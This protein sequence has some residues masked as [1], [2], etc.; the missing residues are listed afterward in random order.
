VLQQL[1]DAERQLLA[2]RAHLATLAGKEDHLAMPN[3]PRNGACE[4]YPNLEQWLHD[5]G[6]SIVHRRPETPLDTTYDR[7]A[8][9]LGTHFD[10]LRPFYTAMKRC[11][12]G[13]PFAIPISLKDATP[14]Q[15]STVVQFGRDLHRHGFLKA[16]RYDQRQRLLY[17]QAQDAG[18]VTNFFTGAW[19]DR[20]VLLRTQASLRRQRV[21]VETLTNLQVVLPDGRDFELDIL[22]GS[23]AGILW[24]ECKTGNNYPEFV[25]RYGQIAKR[26]MCLP[27]TRCA[28]VLLE[29]LTEDE[30]QSNTVL[31]GMSVLNLPDL[32]P[33][34]AR[35][36]HA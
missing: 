8:R 15:M 28:L 9:F 10:T 21:D 35:I 24:L 19:L 36:A 26:Y 25:T 2:L 34:L 17:L 23:L 33:F 20:Y 13:F 14:G 22:I 1:A 4:A 6:I 16:F 7:F 18:P 30:K 32:D 12:A 11:L 3:K 27:A 29:P 31:A 5:R